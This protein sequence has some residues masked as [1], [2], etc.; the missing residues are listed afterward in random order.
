MLVTVTLNAAIDK[1]YR[2]SQLIPGQL[3]RTRE[4][5]SLPGGKG[6]NVA[7][8]A[9]TLGTDV[10]ATGFIAGHNGR[11]IAEGCAK[12]GIA[13]D[14]VET[15]GESRCC[16]SL[17]DEQSGEVTEVLEQGPVVTS[18]AFAQ[19]LD[20]LGR[21]ARQASY[22]AFSGSL[23]AGVPADAYQTLIELVREAGAM[24]VLDTSGSA[25]G[26][27]LK[28]QP[29]LVKPNR[30][31]AEAL[32]GYPLDGEEAIVAALHDL[33]FLG[34]KRVL[35]SLGDAGAWFFAG[36][37]PQHFPVVPLGRVVNPVGCG[38]SLLAG[39]LAGRV[40]GLAWESAIRLGMVSAAA[41]ALSAG[42]GMVDPNTVERMLLRFGAS[43]GQEGR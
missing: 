20:K 14:F 8:V 32:L 16:L 27:G 1:T 42:A 4:H 30:D 38:D 39:V 35:L 43:Q 6:I 34:A 23:P 24:P 40:K 33:H 21:L 12:Q 31:E 36:D 9:R 3:H 26:H 7:R 10:I 22:V 28:G 2:L 13:P 25:L 41:N 19:L 11:F 18:A 15:E 37:E 29:C 5:L 17:L